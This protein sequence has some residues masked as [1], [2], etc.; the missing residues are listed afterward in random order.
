MRFKFRNLL[1]AGAA[2]FAFT[3][4]SNDSDSLPTSELRNIDVSVIIPAGDAQARGAVVDA[5][6]NM[7]P[8]LKNL[9]A[10]VLSGTTVTAEKKIT[11]EDD[12]K[13]IGSKPKDA[14]TVVTG[15]EGITLNIPFSDVMLNG[16]EVVQVVANHESSNTDVGVAAIQPAAEKG[17]QGV[18]NMVYVGKEKI[19]PTD[20]NNG[21]KQYSAKI[22]VKPLAARV[23]LAGNVA[24]DTDV[25]ASL[26]VEDVVPVRYSP[27]YGSVKKVTPLS[28]EKGDL[29]ST[30]TAEN[31]TAI[32]EGK[33]VANHLFSGDIQRIAISLSA[34]VY[35]R[36][37]NE[38]EKSFKG[39]EF[40][41]GH[42]SF[43][44]LDEDKKEYVKDAQGKYFLYEE[45]KAGL[46]EQTKIELKTEPYYAF[47]TLCRFTDK[48]TDKLSANDTHYV[49]GKIY[50]IV[51]NKDVYWN[52]TATNPDDQTKFNPDI[53]T[54]GTEEPDAKELSSVSVKATVLEWTKDAMKVAVE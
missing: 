30:L 38:D 54:G 32:D 47:H 17:Q 37:M 53:N 27:L 36:A 29:W 43:I 19:V 23:E 21:I 11:F 28:S 22:T 34:K 24:F 13:T 40:K 25:V 49:G 18:E 39:Y 50:S 44:Y 45:E 33:V 46:V 5:E 3:A 42:V 6:G 9:T 48:N 52:P 14:N 41:D 26:Q 35:S 16:N 7:A 20:E 8:R 51:L 12:G 31:R 10:Y 4:C 1:L 15:G 2:T